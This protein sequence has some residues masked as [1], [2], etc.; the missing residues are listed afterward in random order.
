MSFCTYGLSRSSAILVRATQL[1]PFNNPFSGDV[2]TET[3]PRTE[4]IS[5]LPDSFEDAVNRAVEKSVRCIE[6]GNFRIR[7]EFDTTIGDATYTSLQN[8]M[9]MIKEMTKCLAREFD[10][11]DPPK[12]V[13]ES[14]FDTSSEEVQVMPSTDVSTSP[15]APPLGS[16]SL[17]KSPL[18]PSLEA[19]KLKSEMTEEE[20]QA[21]AD[22]EV[23]LANGIDL[24]LSQLTFKTKWMGRT[25]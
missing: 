17:S 15:P 16:N 25:F 24:N 13:P 9:P 20:L 7:I 23:M 2:A 4:E 11:E 1:S 14:P 8:T 5:E 12:E 19:T 21:F 10:L 6:S 22:S 18:P 3:H